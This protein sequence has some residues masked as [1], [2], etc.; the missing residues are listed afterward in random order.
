M[1][2]YLAPLQKRF[3]ARYIFKKILIFE[4]FLLFCYTLARIVQLLCTTSDLFKT[5]TK[6]NF[7]EYPKKYTTVPLCYTQT[8]Y[9]LS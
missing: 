3:F 7:F 5:K 4:Q 8:F 9:T 6:N 1:R 2:R